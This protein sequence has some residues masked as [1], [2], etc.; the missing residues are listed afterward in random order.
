MWHVIGVGLR[1]EGFSRE[2]SKAYDE[3]V[4]LRIELTS[5]IS[6]GKKRQNFQ[7]TS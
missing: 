5:P 2:E 1:I 4:V 3:H 6:Q 7:V